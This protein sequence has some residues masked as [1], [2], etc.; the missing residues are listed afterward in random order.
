MKNNG[1]FKTVCLQS[2]LILAIA[3]G[4]ISTP[5]AADVLVNNQGK[6]GYADENG[7]LVVG[8]KYSYIGSF[9][10]NGLALVMKGS[11]CGM[12]NRDGVE[13]LPAIYD[14]ITEF[15][16]GVAQ[17]KKGKKVGLID[18]NARIILKPTY[19]EIGKFNSQNITWATKDKNKINY[20]VIDITG[21]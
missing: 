10:E 3:F 16:H 14:N 20:S 11:K 1:I 17:I 6:F 5:M 2:W 4:L 12:I 8:Y 15:D 7:K 18:A 21:K 9:D 19:L 13:I